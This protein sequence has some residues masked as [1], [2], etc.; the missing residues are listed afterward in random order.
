MKH[1]RISKYQSD[2]FQKFQDLTNYLSRSDAIELP[3]DGKLNGYLRVNNN[4]VKSNRFDLQLTNFNYKN[5]L[6]F[7]L[8]ELKSEQINT[9]SERYN[10]QIYNL[11]YKKKLL[12]YLSS[13]ILFQPSIGL[14][15]LL[16]LDVQFQDRV[17]FQ[18]VSL[19]YNFL[20]DWFTASFL[21]NDDDL[22]LLSLPF[23]GV[24]G[25]SNQEVVL[26]LRPA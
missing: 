25:F 17:I 7:D 1:L 23:K 26:Y 16:N 20:N 13:D 10:F 11:E 9:K 2:N 21:F 14:V 12:T 15:S 22:A 18:P 8:A 4:N 19:K 24:K 5:S 6:F 3:I